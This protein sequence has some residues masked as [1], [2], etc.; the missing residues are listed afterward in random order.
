MAGAFAA[1]FAALWAFLG[2]FADVCSFWQ[3]VRLLCLCLHL[4]LLSALS[5]TLLT[6][7]VEAPLRVV[8]Y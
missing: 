5:A 6:H 7:H 3:R 2:C 8:V 4:R 1:V